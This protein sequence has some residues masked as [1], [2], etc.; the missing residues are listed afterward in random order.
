MIGPAFLFLIVRCGVYPRARF[1]AVSVHFLSVFS[2]FLFVSV[3]SSASASMW[4]AGGLHHK[5]INLQGSL[6]QIY[7]LGN[8]GTL[9]A[10]EFPIQLIH[11]LAPYPLGVHKT[12]SKWEVPQL[13]TYVVPHGDAHMLWVTPG[14]QEVLFKRDQAGANQIVDSLPA[15]LPEGWTMRIRADSPRVEIHSDEGWIYVYQEGE[16]RSL[17]LP[18]G[19]KLYFRTDLIQI[20]SIYLQGNGE[21]TVLLS[22]VYDTLGRLSKIQVGPIWHTFTYEKETELLVEWQP[23]T[24]PERATGFGY[25]DG[26]I[27]TITHPSG[28]REAFSWQSDL[29]RYAPGHGLYFDRFRSPAILLSDDA[30]SYR[31]GENQEGIN[32]I[33]RNQL[34]Q[35]ERLVFNPLTKR[36]IRLDRGGLRHEMQWDTNQ[37]NPA[38]DK[39]IGIIAPDGDA[40]V[41][42]E[43]D[44][45]GQVSVVRKRGEA[46]LTFGY[47]T[48]G[49]VIERRRGA[50]PPFRYSYE[51]ESDNPSK[52]INPFGHAVEYRFRPDG[53]IKRFRD[54]EGGLHQFY[55][56][57]FGR[58]IR[59]VYPMDIWVAYDRDDYGRIIGIAHSN[60]SVTEKAYDAFNQL[61]AVVD[62]GIAWE[63]QYDKRGRVLRITRNGA[64]WQKLAYETSGDELRI[65]TIDDQG[66]RSESFYDRD[67]QLLAETNPLGSTINYQYD[68]I[69]QLEG[70]TDQEAGV[71]RFA[72]DES[73]NIT[74]QTN[75]LE[76]QTKKYYDDLGRLIVRDTS[77]QKIRIGYDAAERISEIDYGKGQVFTYQYD[78]YGRIEETTAGKVKTSFAYT[79]LDQ[80]IGKRT[81]FPDGSMDDLIFTY[82]PSG[83]R[84]TLR[85]RRYLKDGSVTEDSETRYR[86]DTL[87][88]IISID[89]N[90]SPVA[91]YHYDPKTLLLTEKILGNGNRILYEYSTLHQLESVTTVDQDGELVQLVDYIWN[92]RGQLIG[93]EVVSDNR[94]VITN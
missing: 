26:L 77:E 12:F 43:Y 92:V 80:R 20:E 71:I 28:K 21:T 68:P 84:K 52:V 73:G 45:L 33:S 79:A 91:T 86:Y 10:E 24:S 82:T 18:S 78:A 56:D 14:G 54:L 29:S 64:V 90:D 7:T 61:H 23:F 4:R 62:N 94:N 85:L 53:Q 60:G 3:S 1:P 59:R 50:Y 69:G 6:D 63:Y 2:A 83:R 46:P 49:R 89:T 38:A 57:N 67:G 13:I 37:S 66:N 81:T 39:L 74:S 47:D 35:E 31:V 48:Q 19:R 25:R 40:L 16:I 9:D 32:L 42:L 41:Q 30:Y 75:A 72:L 65:V 5:N 44:A 93:K 51:G 87:G 22:A 15:R 88:R 70:W 34:D 11:T 17:S 36:L 55:Y 27:A 58:L 76:Q 8:L